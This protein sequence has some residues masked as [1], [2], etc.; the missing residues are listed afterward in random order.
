MD[1]NLGIQFHNQGNFVE[2]EKIYLEVLKD[3]PN[4]AYYNNL[5]ALLYSQT[6]KWEDA[7]KYSQ[8]AIKL[9]EHPDYME[10][11]AICYYVQ[12]NFKEA[13]PIFE[14]ILE[15]TPKDIDRI[16]DYA[17]LA[18]D[19]EQWDYA[20]KFYSKS[21]ALD[22]R[23]YV[24]MN[25]I[26]LG[27]EEQKQ[28]EKAKGYYESSIKVKPNYWAYHNLGV[29]Y[30]RARD[31]QK[32][33]V[34]LKRALQY[35]PENIE[36]MTSLGMS[37]L[38]MRD[39]ENGYKYYQHR[40]PHIKQRFQNPWDG[41]EHKDSTL[42]I[43]FD[44]GRGDLLMFSRY[45]NFIKDKFKKIIFATFDEMIDFFQYNF[46][47]IEV[48]SINY[49]YTYDYSVNIMELH[50]VLGINFD[51]IPFSEHYLKANEQK[52]LE[53][54]QK[55]FQNNKVKV[56]LF[57]QGNLNVFPY[58]SMK[59]SEMSPLLNIE[60]CQFYS[61]QKGAGIE[62]LEEFKNANIIDL[63]STF[64]NYSDTAAA[65]KNLDVL[66]TIDSSILHMAG[67]LG[68]K[69]LLLLPY[70]SEW[71]WFDDKIK[72]PWYNSVSLFRQEKLYDWSIPVE[73]VCKELT[74]FTNKD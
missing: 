27:L 55:Y 23:D 29:Y 6:G 37:Y 24:A 70:A 58:R 25:N 50:Y 39:F 21:L 19:S 53:Y 30:R 38:S 28:F 15:K 17:K 52:V 2:A 5:L 41:Q 56:G 67:A 69:T 63:G 61:C 3:E 64:N 49:P 34:F 51:N 48:C 9:E 32:S 11:L 62:Q 47:D 12:N 4:D 40:C 65:I 7:Q 59:L 60:N 1:I 22:K 18:K 72:T 57:W 66:I 42:I 54:K 33:I 13:M 68:V 20:I 8:I 46:Q 74:N 36:T 16:R 45:I 14:K 71:R 73:E 35:Q 10:T 31:F 43:Y 26:G 44:G